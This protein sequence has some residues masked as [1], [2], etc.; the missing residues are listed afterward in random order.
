MKRIKNEVFVVDNE[1][2]HDTWKLLKNYRDVVWS[3]ELSVHRV[4]RQF[5]VEYGSSIE[6]FL[7]TV[8]LAGADLSGSE[9]EQQAKCIEHNYQMLALIDNAVDLMRNKHKNGEMYYLV[10]YHT[11]LSPQ[12]PRNIDE[13]IERLAVDGQ[14]ISRS[15]YYDYRKEAVKTLS[16]VLWGYESKECSGVLSCTK[17][18]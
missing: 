5:T 6:E 3:L 4:K 18:K 17:T 7:D 10:L 12:Q 2:Y 8:Y 11:Y 1:H 16:V 15:S 13:I 9:I 14:Y